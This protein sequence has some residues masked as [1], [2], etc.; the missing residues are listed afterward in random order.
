MQNL[1]VAVVLVLVACGGKKEEPPAAAPTP[2]KP[3]PA[4]EPTPPKPEPAAKVEKADDFAHGY[5]HVAG[6]GAATFDQK[7]GH[8]GASML[9]VMQWQTEEI[10]KTLGASSE[11]II[12]N[13]LG[14]GVRL[15]FV[16]HAAKPFPTKPATYKINNRERQITVMGTVKHPDVKDGLS[17]MAPDG[18]F[19]VTAFDGKH[20][21]GKGTLTAKTLPDK[22][23]IKLTFDFDL[24]CYG[25]SNCG[26]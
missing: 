3:A 8:T 7:T 15:S 11:G 25:L 18:T 1:R 5:C 10:R 6:T 20:I 13:C 17:I 26:K 23:E 16:S 24:Q 19:E 14:D 21:A 2:A 9:S 4:A 12:L 22:G